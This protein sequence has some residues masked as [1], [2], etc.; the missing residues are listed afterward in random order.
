MRL[1]SPG[2][3]FQVTDA[4]HEAQPCGCGSCSQLVATVLL[5]LRCRVC[6]ERGA[7]A[8]CQAEFCYQHPIGTGL[9]HGPCAG[10]TFMPT[11]DFGEPVELP[12][13]TPEQM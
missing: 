6:K 2:H 11:V 9:M 3:S 10:Q 13:P 7:I 8:V 12:T 4:S 1:W 5:P